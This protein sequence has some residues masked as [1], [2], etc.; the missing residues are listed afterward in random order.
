M[1]EQRR[2]GKY[3]L[4]MRQ[5]AVLEHQHEYGSQWEA[6]TSVTEKLGPTTETIR[7]WVGQAER[8][9]GRHV[10]LTSDE[11]AELKR[12]VAYIVGS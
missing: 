12:G 11:L 4:E 9:T 6:I 10:G 2:P 8:D 7:R 3:P 1:T 5:R